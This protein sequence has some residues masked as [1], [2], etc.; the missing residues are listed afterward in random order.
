VLS[1]GPDTAEI[2][3]T[4]VVTAGLETINR[5]LN[6]LQKLYLNVAGTSSSN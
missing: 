4:N 1:V 2:E 3:D 5:K 6:I